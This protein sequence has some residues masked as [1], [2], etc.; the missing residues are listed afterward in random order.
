[1]RARAGI[2]LAAVAATALAGCGGSSPK[3]HVVRPAKPVWCPAE[4]KMRG[5]V[6]RPRGRFDA[7]RILGL[8]LADAAKLADANGCDV[9]STTLGKGE[10]L[11]MDLR[12]D[13]VDVVVE[14]DTVA[15]FDTHVG[16]IG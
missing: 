13:R 2:A 5:R 4:V 11:T 12:I 7:R 16:P 8:S 14:H 15:R 6:V 3:V 10:A 1:V 9:R